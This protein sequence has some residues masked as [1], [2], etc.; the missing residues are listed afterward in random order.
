MSY[1]TDS[2]FMHCGKRITITQD[3]EPMNPRID[4]DNAGTMLCWHGRYTLGDQNHASKGENVS[5]TVAALIGMDEDKLREKFNNYSEAL[6]S[7]PL[8]SLPLYLYDHSG[9]TMAT[10]PFSCRWDSGQ[11]GF[12]YITYEKLHEELMCTRPLVNWKPDAGQIEKGLDLLRGE[13]KA[14]D[15]YLRGECYVFTIETKAKGD[16]EWSEDSSVGGFLGNIEYC[17]EAAKEE[18]HG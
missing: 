14:Y 13:V 6:D 2:P 18:A 8:L 7:A 12:T 17:V 5:D 9:I 16:D 3:S 4:Y 15:D 1:E 11:V 10:T